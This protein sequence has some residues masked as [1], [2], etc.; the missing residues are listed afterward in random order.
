MTFDDLQQQWQDSN[1]SAARPSV[2]PD[3]LLRTCRR[4]EK[5]KSEIFRR[6]FI[7][8][9][10][11]ILVII[12]FG[13]MTFNLASW[14]SKM[15]SFICVCGAIF[16]IYKLQR[17][18]KVQGELR[19][20]VS[21]REYCRMEIERVKNQIHLLQTITSWYIAPCIVG[22]NL[23]YAGASSS[24]LATSIYF[25][26][27]LLFS[28]LVYALNQRVVTKEFVPLHEELKSLKKELN[29]PNTSE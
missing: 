26:C 4:T 23:V 6:D 20:D 10:A 13:T 24:W 28:W 22:A 11:G 18:R 8:I 3:T 17:G 9:A 1:E 15:G 29:D 27:T 21:V 12:W 16:I 14:V 19:F 5:F 25:V 7:E 2:D